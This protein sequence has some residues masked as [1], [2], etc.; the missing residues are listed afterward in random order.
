MTPYEESR[1]RREKRERQRDDRNDKIAACVG[2]AA[3][4]GIF[5]GI[6]LWSIDYSTEELSEP[7]RAR[8]AVLDAGYTQPR[9]TGVPSEQECSTRTRYEQRYYRD[10]FQ[11]VAPNGRTVSLIVCRPERSNASSVRVSASARYRY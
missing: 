8:E 10:A 9:H 6:A 1:A 4:M 7:A 2:A 3:V 5:G 11:A